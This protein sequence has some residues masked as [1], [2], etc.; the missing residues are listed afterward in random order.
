MTNREWIMRQLREMSNDHLA[1]ALMNG[2][3]LRL[4]ALVCDDCRRRNGG[5]P[6][7][8]EDEDCGDDGSEAVWLARERGED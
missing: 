8:G 1:R 5:C 7:P 4:S 3:D 6:H 2:I